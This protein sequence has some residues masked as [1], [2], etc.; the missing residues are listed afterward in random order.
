MDWVDCGNASETNTGTRAVFVSAEGSRQAR[1]R[2]RDSLKGL[3]IRAQCKVCGL[4]MAWYAKENAQ[5]EERNESLQKSPILFVSDHAFSQLMKAGR[6][7]RASEFSNVRSWNWYT[8]CTQ[9]LVNEW[10]FI[11][12]QPEAHTKRQATQHNCLPSAQ[13]AGRWGSKGLI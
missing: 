2:F 13:L 8:L 5:K 6:R 9:S 3:Q 4:Q 1:N 12:S 7:E 10:A 11:K